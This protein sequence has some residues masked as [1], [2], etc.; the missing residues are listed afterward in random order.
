MSGFLENLLGMGKRLEEY[1]LGF[2]KLC[3]YITFIYYYTLPTGYKSNTTK[4]GFKMIDFAVFNV[5][6]NKWV[7]FV[8]IN[9]FFLYHCYFNP[10]LTLLYSLLAVIYY[11]HSITFY[12]NQFD[13]CIF[14]EH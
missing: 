11:L 9:A 14:S 13:I 7:D 12:L 1:D 5:A 8:K 2:C 10:H 6:D 4:T 3:V